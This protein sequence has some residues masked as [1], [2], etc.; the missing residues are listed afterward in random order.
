MEGG[1]DVSYIDLELSMTV[2]G[3]CTIVGKSA[4]GVLVYVVTETDP[5]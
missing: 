5:K 4:D 2:C 1:S 3:V